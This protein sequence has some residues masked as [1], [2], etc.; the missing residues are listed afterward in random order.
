MLCEDH[1]T[2]SKSLSI[3]FFIVF[4]ITFDDS[5]K[6]LWINNIQIYNQIVDMWQAEVTS[7]WGAREIK[8]KDIHALSTLSST[9]AMIQEETFKK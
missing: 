3:I 4:D 1:H 7:K 8:T 2:F 5:L 6:G 9:V